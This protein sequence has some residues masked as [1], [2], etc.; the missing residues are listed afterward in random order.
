M[1]EGDR[2][3]VVVIPLGPGRQ[4]WRTRVPWW[5]LAAVLAVFP[6]TRPLAVLAAVVGVVD[7]VGRWRWQ[8]VR[9]T[10]SGLEVR[11][12]FAGPSVRWS[13]VAALTAAPAPARH[14]VGLAVDA[15]PFGAAPRPPLLSVVVE[16]HAEPTIR[17][18]LAD[19]HLDIP[20]N[21][22]EPW[23]DRRGG[24]H[25]AELA[26]DPFETI[27]S[28]Q[29]AWLGPWLVRIDTTP[30]RARAMVIDRRTDAAVNEA[31][32]RNS[33]EGATNDA[34]RFIAAARRDLRATG[35][36]AA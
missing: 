6:I 31:P 1:N 7:L 36:P 2:D 19:H 5:Y 20:V 25:A 27:R 14:G 35:R 4:G 23:Q 3:D 26:T 33:V 12:R 8:R 9:L 11:R 32:W 13:E 21:P 10:P 24:W 29:R 17:Q 28:I 16:E 18:F 22:P 30:R 34:E 15:V